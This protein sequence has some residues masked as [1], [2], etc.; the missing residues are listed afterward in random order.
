MPI[1]FRV[2]PLIFFLL[3]SLPHHPVSTLFDTFILKPMGMATV[4]SA[5][6]IGSLAL[7][8]A[9]AVFTIRG[10]W[11]QP[12]LPLISL[13]VLT[14]LLSYF[15]DRYLIVNNIERIH[16]PQY[17]ILAILLKLSITNDVIV[18]FT[19][20]FA[21][22]VD[23]FLQYVMNPTRTSYLDFNDFVLNVLGAALGL[24]LFRVLIR[25]SPRQYLEYER[26]FTLGLAA[27]V[28]GAAGAL[29]V[30]VMLHRIIP[31][32]EL[33]SNLGPLSFIE[34]KLYLVLS[35]VRQ[36]EFWTVA[37]H[38]KKFHV[39]SLEE[40]LIVLGLLFLFYFIAFRWL[41]E[42]K[43]MSSSKFTGES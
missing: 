15:S 34:G 26:K 14:L 22:M 17:A 40:G 30:G 27:V 28:S 18:F 32:M 39:L 16:F 1:I 13:F 5:I 8:G 25:T 6:Q 29:A 4:Q 41:L 36:T 7:M 31:Y 35:F 10:M 19:A 42:Q 9:V 2:I 20:S 43:N 3:V 12:S 24:L 37:F 21:G 33:K 23:E 38:G 11:A